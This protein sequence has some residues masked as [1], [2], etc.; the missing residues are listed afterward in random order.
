MKS[1]NVVVLGLKSNFNDYEMLCNAAL[2]AGINATLTSKINVIFQRN[3]IC[4]L[5]NTFITAVLFAI[6][7]PFNSCLFLDTRTVPIDVK[8]ISRLHLKLTHIL[9][10]VFSKRLIFQDRMV[11]HGF[12]IDEF[13]GSFAP[14]GFT[15]NICN[16]SRHNNKAVY[17]GSVKGRMMDSFFK[18]PAI[19]KLLESRQIDF[20]G[21]RE[22]F[23]ALEAITTVRVNYLGEVSRGELLQNISHYEFGISF[24]GNPVYKCQVPTK[25]YDCISAG[26]PVITSSS[27]AVK[28]FFKETLGVLII[29]EY[30]DDGILE[31]LSSINRNK[32]KVGKPLMNEMWLPWL[33]QNESLF[34]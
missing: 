5:H 32:I 14:L 11:A 20:F 7:A 24:I 15:A 18:D 31:A 13:S 19:S 1:L 33:K 21:K 2:E 30:R 9:S 29:E 10:L 17:F 28:E 25:I 34:T 8:F 27:P 4:I 12:G 6:L 3:S 16:K 22:D 26:I 23:E